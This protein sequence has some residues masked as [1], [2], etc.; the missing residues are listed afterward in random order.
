[1]FAM[2]SEE[3]QQTHQGWKDQRV[4][5]F[6]EDGLIDEGHKDRVYCLTSI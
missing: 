1:M 2:E 5:L 3:I 6:E 4:F